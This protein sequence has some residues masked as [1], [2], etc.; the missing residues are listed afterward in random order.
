MFM[1]DPR[2]N[3]SE[4]PSRKCVFRCFLVSDWSLLATL[5]NI[6]GN[7]LFLENCY[8]ELTFCKSLK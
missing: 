4:W 8:L 6:P 3:F 1:L 7:D 5:K 2:P